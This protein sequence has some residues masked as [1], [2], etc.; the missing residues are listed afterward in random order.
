MAASG[1]PGLFICRV[2]GKSHTPTH[3]MDDVR[4]APGV[5]TPLHAVVSALSGRIKRLPRRVSIERE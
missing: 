4:P 2:R 1:L 3:Q 5:I